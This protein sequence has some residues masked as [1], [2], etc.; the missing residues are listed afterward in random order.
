MATASRRCPN[1][2]PPPL[3]MRIL[4]LK[5][6]LLLPLDKGG[7]LRTWHLMRHLAARHAITYLAFA[8][9]DQI[10]PGGHGAVPGIV[11]GMRKVAAHVEI[12][13]RSE[14]PKGS[15]RF[16]LDAAVHV[17][18]PLPYAVGKYRSRAF[19]RRLNALLRERRFD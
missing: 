14:P 19:R 1:P 3:L 18:D 11:E 8:E 9:R 13:P 5:S 10:A 12:V 17:L 6:D 16:Y 7:R 2:R 4:W 15:W